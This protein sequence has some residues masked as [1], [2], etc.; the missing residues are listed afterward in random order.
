MS[1][2]KLPERAKGWPP[3]FKITDVD[4]FLEAVTV[5]LAE[6][7]VWRF[8]DR[9]KL[10]PDHFLSANYVGVEFAGKDLWFALCSFGH[11]PSK[12][13]LTM[14]ATSWERDA[15][16]A[17]DTQYAAAERLSMLIF[18]TAG[19]LLR[20]RLTLSRPPVHRPRHSLSGRLGE[21]F[22]GFCAGATDVWNGGK[23][24]YLK[25][26]EYERFFEFICAAHRGCSTLTP[27]ELAGMLSRA[28]FD[29][30]LC[31]ELVDQFT[32]ARRALAINARARHV[33]AWNPWNARA[34]RKQWRTLYQSNRGDQVTDEP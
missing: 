11:D 4:A 14:H 19:K 18:R 6:C 33:D 23:L 12:V 31:T 34:D 21:K 10:G 26:T 8:H 13:Q 28:G 27:G 22:A 25:Q 30:A 17:S 2:Q 29:D 1:P 9:G 20:R 16:T 7:R 5:A 3:F 24:H 32:I 15:C